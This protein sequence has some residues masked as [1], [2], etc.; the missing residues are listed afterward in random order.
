MPS[1]DPVSTPPPSSPRLLADQR[2]HV[3]SLRFACWTPRDERD[4]RRQQQIQGPRLT[5]SE[6]PSLLAFGDCGPLTAALL[7]SPVTASAEKGTGQTAS[8]GDTLALGGQSQKGY[9]LLQGEG[10]SS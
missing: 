9:W 6:A 1:K 2:R 5:T 3:A 7:Q 8:A 10:V 4:P